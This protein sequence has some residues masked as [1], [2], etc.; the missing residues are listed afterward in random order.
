M[1][2]EKQA[3]KLYVILTHSVVCSEESGLPKTLKILDSFIFCKPQEK[4]G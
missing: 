3:I 4:L 2:I 1:S